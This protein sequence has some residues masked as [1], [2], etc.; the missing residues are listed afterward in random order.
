LAAEFMAE[1]P[2]PNVLDAGSTPGNEA[3]IACV[4][5]RANTKLKSLAASKPLRSHILAR[6]RI[7]THDRRVWFEAQRTRPER[8]SGHRHG[9]HAD[10]LRVIELGAA[11]AQALAD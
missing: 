8:R 5:D 7:K 11:T 2:T 4:R 10:T 6:E 9:A 1:G 3:V